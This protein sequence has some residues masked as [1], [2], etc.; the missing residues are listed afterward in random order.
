VDQDP[1]AGGRRG[2]QE[3]QHGEREDQLEV[4]RQAA[5]ARTLEDRAGQAL[6][7]PAAHH[8][9]AHRQHADQEERDGIGEALERVAQARG[10]AA[11]SQERH[12]DQGADARLQDLARPEQ[13]G[14]QRDDQRPLAGE[15]QAGQHRR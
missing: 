1:R 6:G 2:Q 15:R 5:T 3:G 14:D 13:D 9:D 10:R 7:Q 4:D 8:G 12:A 11:Q